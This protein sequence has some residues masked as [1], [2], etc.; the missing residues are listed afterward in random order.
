MAATA[1]GE[2]DARG[3]GADRVDVSTPPGIMG[4]GGVAWIGPNDAA[5]AIDVA[6][7]GRGRARSKKTVEPTPVAKMMPNACSIAVCVAP[8]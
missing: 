6:I 7:L 5:A 8:G 4:V 3:T 1:A 2:V